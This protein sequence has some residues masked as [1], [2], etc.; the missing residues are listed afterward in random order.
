[1]HIAR[2]FCGP[3]IRPI[4]SHRPL[5]LQSIHRPDLIPISQQA[6]NLRSGG[7]PANTQSQ[8][9]RDANF[10]EAVDNVVPKME[11]EPQKVTQAE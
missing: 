5:S 7:A 3:A 4:T 1:V 6:P 8:G 9:T 10:Q 2:A 11:N